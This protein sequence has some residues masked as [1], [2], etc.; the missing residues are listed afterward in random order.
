MS[1]IEKNSVVS[2]TS[3]LTLSLRS[4]WQKV[5]W[6]VI[7]HEF[8]TLFS[9]RE[10]KMVRRSHDDTQDSFSV[11]KRVLFHVFSIQVLQEEQLRILM[12]RNK[13]KLISIGSS[14]RIRGLRGK[15]F[16]IRIFNLA[17]TEFHN[18]LAGKQK[19]LKELHSKM[20][21][22]R[23]T[24]LRSTFYKIDKIEPKSKFVNLT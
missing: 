13:N 18:D 12:R 3:C 17:L 10:V 5:V 8:G 16:L 4:I 15:I 7:F 21:I 11:V 22:P 1:V 9:M 23:E 19:R 6:N 2:L 24:F 20:R 14:Q